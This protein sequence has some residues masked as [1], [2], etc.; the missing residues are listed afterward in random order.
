MLYLYCNDRIVE[1]SD[2][3]DNLIDEM[4][5]MEHMFDTLEFELLDSGDRRFSNIL[6]IEEVTDIT[7]QIT[8]NKEGN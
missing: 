7:Y 8:P 3:E 4:F 1:K 5:G 2:S 6:G